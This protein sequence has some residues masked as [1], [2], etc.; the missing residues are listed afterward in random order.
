ML[1]KNYSKTGRFCRVTFK[2]SPDVG[3]QQAILYGDFNDWDAGGVAM[4]RLKDGGFSVTLSLPAGN[5]YRYRYRLDDNR[6]E[7][8]WEA[9][10]YTPNRFGSEDSIV[11]L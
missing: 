8:D 6:W 4:K 7:N 5:A 1:I 9:D 10:A 3:A 11:K 2:L